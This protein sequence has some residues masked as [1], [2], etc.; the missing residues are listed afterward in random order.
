MRSPSTWKLALALPVV[1]LAG[2]GAF[3]LLAA[4]E[5]SAWA[6]ER[7]AGPE[8]CRRVGAA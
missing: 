3:A 1:A 8:P 6:S 5:V 7:P 4:W 2:L